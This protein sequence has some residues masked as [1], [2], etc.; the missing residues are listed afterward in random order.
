MYLFFRLW[1]INIQH[2]TS[3]DIIIKLH[4]GYKPCWLTSS[5]REKLSSSIHL[6]VGCQIEPKRKDLASFSF[7]LSLFSNLTAPYDVV[8]NRGFTFKLLRLLPDKHMVR[9]IMELVRNRGF[10]LTARD[11]K[12]SRLCRLKNGV[13]QGSVLA[14]SFSTSISASC[15]PR[16]PETL[17]ILT[18]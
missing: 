8:W 18:I 3:Y 1:N 14:A 17:L 16:F 12:Q 2:R 15:P 11:R 13:P 7:F 4:N 10:T 5:V 6:T 9:M